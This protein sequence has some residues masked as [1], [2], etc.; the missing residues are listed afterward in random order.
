MDL[1]VEVHNLRLVNA[2]SW[3][4]VN[5]GNRRTTHNNNR[6]SRGV[7]VLGRPDLGLEALFFRSGSCEIVDLMVLLGKLRS[8]LILLGLTPYFVAPITCPRLN[9]VN[10]FP[11]LN[12]CRNWG[13]WRPVFRHF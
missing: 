12:I 9:G 10:S 6:S 2:R 8:L 7:Y 1:R 5:F 4:Y 3:E 11:L 13:Q